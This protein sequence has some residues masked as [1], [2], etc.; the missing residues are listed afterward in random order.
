MLTHC[1]DSRWKQTRFTSAS[2]NEHEGSTTRSTFKKW[3]TLGPKNGRTFGLGTTWR[4]H[5]TAHDW[6][7]TSSPF[8]SKAAH[9]SRYLPLPACFLSL[10]TQLSRWHPRRPSTGCDEAGFYLLPM[11]VRTWAPRG[12]TPILRVK[13]TRDQRHH[14]GWATV[15][16]SAP[17][18]L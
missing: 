5:T 3:L 1:T 2:T 9:L 8:T 17:R 11:A 14:A 10:V 13:L 7:V 15:H 6:R 4:L 18:L 16:A 12:Q